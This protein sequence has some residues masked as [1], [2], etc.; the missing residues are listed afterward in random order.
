MA[1]GRGHQK[2][3]ATPWW[4]GGHEYER[5]RP[6]GLHSMITVPSGTASP[7]CDLAPNT[8]ASPSPSLRLPLESS[9]S[10][11]KAN[12]PVADTTMIADSLQRHFIA[13]GAVAELRAIFKDGSI[14]AGFF[15]RDHADVM[16]REAERLSGL[17]RV[18][19]VYVTLNA[20]DA[21]L[22]NRPGFANQVRKVRAGESASAKDVK[23]RVFLLIDADPRRAEGMNGWSASDDEKAK[24]LAKVLEIRTYLS[25]LGWPEPLLCDSGNGWHLLYR[26]DLPADDSG[27]LKRVLGAL[28]KRFDDEAVEIDRKVYDPARITKL[29]GTRACKGEH[30]ADR[31][32]RLSGIVEIPSVLTVVSREAMEALGAEVLVEKARK[33]SVKTSTPPNSHRS[34]AIPIFPLDQKMA[35]ARAH[36]KTMDPAIEGHGGDKQTYM[37]A[38]RLVLGCDLRPDEALPLMVEYN[39]RCVPPWTEAALR[40]KLERADMESG[41]R[42]YLLAHGNR[43]LAVDADPDD[44]SEE[45][46]RSWLL[47]GIHNF[48][49]IDPDRARLFEV[50]G[51]TRGLFSG[52][53]TWPTLKDVRAAIAAGQFA[54]GH[55]AWV[56]TRTIG[57]LRARSLEDNAQWGLR[58]FSTKMG[59]F[60]F[61][62]FCL[63]DAHALAMSPSRTARS[64]ADAPYDAAI[65][66]NM[67]KVLDMFRHYKPAGRILW[68]LQSRLLQA[69]SNYLLLADTALAQVGFGAMY[70]SDPN[71]R[72]HLSDMLGALRTLCYGHLVSNQTNVDVVFEADRS[73]LLAD[74]KDL[75]PPR[76]S[77]GCE[78]SC[79]LWCSRE[80]HG[81]FAVKVGDLFLGRL[82]RFQVNE[83]QGGIKYFDFNPDVEAQVR[84]LH[85]KFDGEDAVSSASEPMFDFE[86]QEYRKV[87][88]E[89]KKELSRRIEEVRQQHTAKYEGIVTTAILP[90]IFGH[91]IGLAAVHRKVLRV[92]MREMTRARRKRGDRGRVS[93]HIFTQARVPSSHRHPMC[94]C[95]LLSP[96]MR[97]V[98]LAG[99]GRAGAW[100]HGYRLEMWLSRANYLRIDKAQ[101]PKAFLTALRSFFAD[102]AGMIAV[103]DIMPVGI[104]NNEFFDFEQVRALARSRSPDEHEL[105]KL[106]EMCLR[107]YLPAD[108]ASRW[109]KLV[110]S[111]IA[112]PAS[113]MPPTSEHALLDLRVEMQRHGIT[114]Q[115]LAGHL[116]CHRT[117]LSRMLRSGRMTADQ[118]GKAMAF[119]K[120]S[121]SSSP[122]Q[123]G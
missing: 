21:N 1:D 24:A 4:G 56:H 71:W 45:E 62:G 2:G 79:P 3:V 61:I 95:R 123:G 60:P 44:A 23:R 28:A 9:G 42:G 105:R 96:R 115:E 6:L 102:L 66:P 85:G 55:D 34:S 68:Y 27:L 70:R 97:Y 10:P 92:M 50:I 26:I 40:H 15:D 11:L 7:T 83:K 73:R 91:V 117:R 57:G 77:A 120:S 74:V 14:H 75:G 12:A 94:T 118:L 25:S 103:L 88:R 116:G 119:I 43:P 107:F 13:A 98:A 80:K 84:E 39:D 52:M 18:K 54:S 17:P 86:E 31:P 67:A 111:K 37:V 90:M 35:S 109:R 63:Q 89:R 33:S 36:I 99:N 22:L 72:Q 121:A 53:M 106:R 122:S 58:V 101:D 19:G 65:E 59:T 82:G 51:T 114:Q 108:F 29:Y 41:E 47:D 5:P 113:T 110:A 76:R 78:P 38:C 104:L 100:G 87:Q 69:K 32:H 112:G 20:I 64:M 46:P 81:H 16:A 30:T 48:G 8:A 49:M 93:P